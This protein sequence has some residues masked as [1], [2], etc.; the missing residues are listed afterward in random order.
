MD[1]RAFDDAFHTIPHLSMLHR[2]CCSV[3][4]LFQQLPQL[5]D[6]RGCKRKRK[7]GLCCKYDIRD[8]IWFPV[9]VSLAVYK[10]VVCQAGITSDGCWVIRTLVVFWCLSILSTSL[11]GA[12]LFIKV[13]GLN[14][15]GVFFSCIYK[16]MTDILVVHK[17]VELK[18]RGASLRLHATCRLFV[19]GDKLQE[20]EVWFGP[21]QWRLP[22]ASPRSKY[23]S[24]FGLRPPALSCSILQSGR[25]SPP[26]QHLSSFLESVQKHA[27]TFVS[28][29]LGYIHYP[30]VQFLKMNILYIDQM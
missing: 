13:Q 24:A 20:G 28:I 15:F 5:I 29:F 26:T 30:S 12:S 21:W 10:S 16:H 19:Q 18:A 22:S 1:T 14:I 2:L 8:L 9:F 25:P 17:E 7:R 3:S 27:H 6:L 23:G 11:R 4:Q